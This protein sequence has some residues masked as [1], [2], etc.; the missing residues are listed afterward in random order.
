MMLNFTVGPVQMDEAV[1]KVGAEQLPYFRTTEFS[2]IMKENEE[3]IKKFLKAEDSARTVFLTTS[4]TGAMEGS[5]MNTL[6]EKDKVIVV[7]GGSFG[8][9]FAEICKIHCIPY[10]EI[11]LDMGESLTKE[12]LYKLDGK[13]Y[14]SLLVN[15]C[16]TSSG[17][18]YDIN[19]ISE[20]CKKNNIF[21]IV[22]SVSSFIA[23]PF[24]MKDL[25]VDVV[26]TGSQKA[27]ALSPGLSIIV[28][29]KKA[30]QRVKKNKVKSLYFDFKNYLI[31][32]E[33]GQTPFTPAVGTIIQLNKRLKMIDMDGIDK[34]TEKIKYIAEDFRKRIK[35]LP[36]EIVT[37][38]IS[39]SVTPLSPIGNVSAFY[40]F[41][42]LKDEYNIFICPNGGKLKEKMFRVGH[43]GTLTIDDNITLINAF[44]D[45][46]RRGIL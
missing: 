25:M 31:D 46:V 36:L 10:T 35:E 43:I 30:I 13:G 45:L 24:N 9:R 32:G 5:V 1:L 18:Y 39:N 12:E 2:T 11:K 38:A 20:F 26:L 19:M 28:L 14:T 21:L 44:K 27:L 16:E 22:D 40:I 4:G 33:R 34:E 15:L 41:E 6:D 8:E 29:N 37:N 3:L 7:N 23:D 17:V 42:I